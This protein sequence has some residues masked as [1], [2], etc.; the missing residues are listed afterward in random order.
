MGWLIKNNRSSHE[1]DILEMKAN[2]NATRC[3]HFLAR[4][5]LCGWH[6]KVNL[7]PRPIDS[8]L[9]LCFSVQ[10]LLQHIGIVRTNFMAFL[11]SC[12]IS[13]AFRICEGE[14]SK[15]EERMGQMFDV[16]RVN[17][18]RLRCDRWNWWDIN[19]W[20]VSKL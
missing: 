14:N 10:C 15:N 6:S 8:L 12:F 1:S 9:S 2:Q 16:E 4:K 13:W 18:S 20:S 7:T 17:S 11:F 5:I 3:F 19:G